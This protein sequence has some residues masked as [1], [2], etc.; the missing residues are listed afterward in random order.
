MVD[1]NVTF[2]QSY[3]NF[4]HTFTKKCDFK[5]KKYSAHMLYTNMYDNSERYHDNV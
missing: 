4:H 2:V 5:R 1:R 3:Y